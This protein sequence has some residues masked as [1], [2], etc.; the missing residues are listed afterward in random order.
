M[1]LWGELPRMAE[2]PSRTRQKTQPVRVK[3]LFFDFG[4]LQT[5]NLTRPPYKIRI[6]STPAD[7]QNRE[8]H[9]ASLL[10]TAGSEK[11]DDFGVLTAF[12]KK[13]VSADHGHRLSSYSTSTITVPSVIP[14]SLN[15]STLTYTFWPSMSAPMV[16][17]GAKVMQL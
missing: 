14:F 4:G 1:P 17:S 2:H 5:Q 15:A 3:R 6:L 7:L 12:C 9:S 11:A 13:P 16:L 8:S 10:Y